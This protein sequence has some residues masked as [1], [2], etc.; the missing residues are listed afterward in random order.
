MKK[1]NE[2]KNIFFILD[3]GMEDEDDVIPLPNVNSA[4]MKRV[5][6]IVCV[7]VFFR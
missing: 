2:I 5:S 7:V 6:V 3:L 1:K 4:I